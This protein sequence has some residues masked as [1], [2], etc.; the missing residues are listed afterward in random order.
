M[1]RGKL[2]GKRMR[3][4][5]IVALMHLSKDL[6]RRKLQW[7]ELDGVPNDVPI[8]E[9]E[10]EMKAIVWEVTRLVRDLSLDWW[11]LSLS[12]QR[13]RLTWELSDAKDDLR[14][15]HQQTSVLM[16]N[17][18]FGMSVATAPMLTKA[19]EA[20]LGVHQYYSPSPRVADSTKELMDSIASINSK[21]EDFNFA[22]AKA[23][24]T[25]T[26][27]STQTDSTL[28]KQPTYL[29][30]LAKL[31]KLQD[32]ITTSCPAADEESQADMVS[33]SP[34]R[35]ADRMLDAPLPPQSYTV[36]PSAEVEASARA[37]ADPA[38]GKFPTTARLDT[39]AESLPS[40]KKRPLHRTP[41]AATAPP[42][43]PGLNDVP[44]IVAK[45]FKIVGKTQP[46]KPKI[47]CVA[48][49]KLLLHEVASED[50]RRPFD[51]ILKHRQKVYAA[52][53]ID[54]L[55]SPVG[56]FLYRFFALKYG[57]RHVAEMYLVNFIASVKKFWKHDPEAVDLIQKLVRESP[58]LTSTLS[59]QFM[60]TAAFQYVTHVYW[61]FAVINN[62]TGAVAQ[63]FQGNDATLLDCVNAMKKYV[64][65][66]QDRLHQYAS[67]GGA[68]ERANFVALNTPEKIATF[69]QTAAA[70][71]KKCVDVDE[72]I[73]SHV[74]SYL[75]AIRKALD[76]LDRKPNEPRFGLTW[77]EFPTSVDSNCNDPNGDYQRCYNP[78]IGEVVYHPPAKRKRDTA[79]VPS[80]RPRG[81]IATFIGTPPSAMEKPSTATEATQTPS[82]AKAALE[83]SFYSKALTLVKHQA[84]VMLFNIALPVAIYNLAKQYTSEI[85]AVFLS[86]VIPMLKTLV[87]FVCLKQ[88]DAI[89]V[90]QVV[91]VLVTVAITIFAT[92]P[93]TLLVFQVGSAA[94]IGVFM[95]LSV[96]WLEEDLF[97]QFRRTMSV[98]TSEE[99]D[100]HYEKPI[101][102]DTSR[103]VTVLMG[104]I[105]I[106]TSIINIFLVLTF[107]VDTIIYMSNIMPLVN[108][109]FMYWLY[110]Y[111]NDKEAQADMA[112]EV[113]PLVQPA[114]DSTVDVVVVK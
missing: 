16:Q 63:T 3:M 39:P 45:E 78:T 90:I 79:C 66:G 56:E 15:V 69:G 4:A 34:S 68:T 17:I 72:S 75:L 24:Q 65:P 46:H 26:T 36:E 2:A 97:Y 62:K 108:I 47:M 8:D 114:A 95:I 40:S 9:L 60:K 59:R 50:P 76:D 82:N 1:A 74:V 112:N 86:G 6:F 113:T 54:E 23:K 32:A 20:R 110:R 91:G 101:V 57:L 61:G 27:A 18:S 44:S 30:A 107:S 99:L 85:V 19:H 93:K 38:V 41:K 94:P 88:Q 106:T 55:R 64:R 48:Q 102:R 53:A 83:P 81:A 22:V 10:E 58:L 96:H 12:V 35:S 5:R 14:H 92:D 80:R 25:R 67:I 7:Q 104:G 42:P 84:P 37:V 109:P 100:L 87:T 77:D 98:K 43:V 31:A 89:S 111:V 28:Q 105:M 71:V 29:Q 13:A 33:D 52:R 70:L 51:S 49:L 103:F 21:L 11:K 73:D